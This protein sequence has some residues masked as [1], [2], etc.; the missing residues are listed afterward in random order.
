MFLIA[1][2]FGNNR[3]RNFASYKDRDEFIAKAKEFIT[4]REKELLTEIE[5]IKTDSNASSAQQR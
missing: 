1:K 3:S 4:T 5:R 2:E